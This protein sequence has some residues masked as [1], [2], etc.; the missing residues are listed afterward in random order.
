[1]ISR[2]DLIVPVRDRRHRKRV[3]TLKNLRI[4][5][6]VFA[7]LVVAVTIQSDFRHPKRGDYGRLFGKQ[8]SGQPVVAPQKVDVVREAPVPEQ[9]S[10]DPLLIAAAAREQ[11]LGTD[12]PL[13]PPAVVDGGVM[14]VQPLDAPRGNVNIVSGPGGV[15]IVRGQAAKRPTLAGGIFR[16]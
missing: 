5:L 12:T 9:P 8:V 10:A 13:P 1:M 3:L 15:T 16:Q 14:P 2:P 11:Y 7:V 6:L 4:A